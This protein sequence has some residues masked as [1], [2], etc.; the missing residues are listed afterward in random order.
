MMSPNQYI[1]TDDKLTVTYNL[2]GHTPLP[3]EPTLTY[4]DGERTLTFQGPE[5]RV[6]HAEFGTL[7]SVTLDKTIDTGSTS[8]SVLIPAIE[9]A[10]GKSERTFETAGVNTEHKITRLP[11]SREIY[12]IYEM[13]G[14]A[15]VVELPLAAKP[16]VASSAV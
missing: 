11:G 12:E 10:D 3:L 13:Q 6:A 7:V 14:S 8:F 1:F 5:I 16:G 15:R 9:L 4:N 2:L